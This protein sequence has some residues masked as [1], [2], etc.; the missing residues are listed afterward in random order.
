MQIDI[1]EFQSYVKHFA[2]P[3][4]YDILLNPPNMDELNNF[5]I[6]QFGKTVRIFA[7]SLSIP[8]NSTQVN[9]Q[10]YY[11]TIYHNGTVV[12]LDSVIVTFYDTSTAFFH[13]YFNTW[14]YGRFDN[15]GVLKYYPDEYSGTMDIYLNDNKI[16]T[17]EKLF[18]ISVG[19]FRL[20]NEMED[21]FGTFDVT[22]A[23]TN[24]KIAN[25]P[26]ES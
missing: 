2:K 12:T 17:L 19:D 16:Y 10:Y 3:N 7:K 24:L 20:D 1:K 11:N 25:L 22:F 8:S 15:S 21:E 26:F 18:P 9:S 23:I 13:R 14:Q 6:N 5:N 4:N